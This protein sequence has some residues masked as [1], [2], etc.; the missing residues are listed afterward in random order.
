MYRSV[1]YN[2]MR[3]R[4]IAPRRGATARGVHVRGPAADGGGAPRGLPHALLRAPP[5]AAQG[6]GTTRE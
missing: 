2:G 5:A 3:G 4:D 6:N 1:G